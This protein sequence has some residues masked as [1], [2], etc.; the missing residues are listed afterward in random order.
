MNNLYENFSKW[1]GKA[2]DWVDGGK[3]LMIAFAV[4]GAVLVAQIVFIVL[5]KRKCICSEIASARVSV[6]RKRVVYFIAWAAAAYMFLA[7]VAYWLPI[8][9]LLLVFLMDIILSMFT[10]CKCCR[11]AP[12][13]KTKN[14]KVKAVK[15]KKVRDDIV[16]VTYQDEI[17]TEVEN[18]EI[19][20]ESEQ[21]EEALQVEEQ[22][23]IEVV[24][25]QNGQIVTEA[26]KGELAQRVEQER[27]A[28]EQ[29][30][31]EQRAVMEQKAAEERAA[32]QRVIEQKQAELERQK[33][34]LS[35]QHKTSA[36]DLAKKRAEEIAAQKKNERLE[37]LAEKIERQ[38]RAAEKQTDK[39]VE[40]RDDHY[41]SER[42]RNALHSAEETANKMDELQRRMEAL[43][44]TVTT[45]DVQTTTTVN[46][47]ETNVKT[48]TE[49]RREK[50]RLAFQYNTLQTRLTQMSSDRQAGVPSKSKFDESEVKVALLG[51]K[52][53]MDDLQK[54]IDSSEDK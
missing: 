26:N 11:V 40:H 52:G 53:A 43:R 54:K 46:R 45:R 19:E 24:Q 13:K 23:K 48:V 7:S 9:M 2:F 17:E 16:D 3:A 32:Q 21:V 50:D 51:L 8:T 38:R 20:V 49:L 14:P 10:G 30:I 36:V 22:K 12:T 41:S 29:R 6:G 1:L 5:A 4:L 31:A 34:S 37:E 47:N 27:R 39:M 18:D 44:K 42:S 28:V 15:T 33:V 25:I 35:A